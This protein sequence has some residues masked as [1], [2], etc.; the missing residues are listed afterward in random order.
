MSRR[1]VATDFGGPENLLLVDVDVPE[2]GPGQV[3]VAVRAAGV[4]PVDVKSYS[5]A[6]GTDP[7]QL[8]K[9]LGSEASGT[10]T[11]VGNDVDVRVGDEVA[12]FRAPGAYATDLLVEADAVVAKPAEVDWAD[13]AGLLLTGSTAMHALT[14]TDVA[15]GE[16]VLVHGGS[17]GVGLMAVQ[18]AAGRGARVIATASER[19][20]ALLRELGAEPVVYGAGLLE[21]VRGLAP[22]GV[23]AALDLIGTDEALE[24][25]LA[26]VEDRSRIATIVNFEGGGDAGIKVLGGGPGADPGDE[27]RQAARPD[28]LAMVARGELRVL[29]EATYPLAEAGEAHQRIAGGHVTGKLVLLP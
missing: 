15:E 12:V 4:N 3:R 19:N 2:P 5:G 21:R 18:L 27:L 28:L 1:V 17:G 26:L 29:V 13:A 9:P 25:S 16:T 8:P 24:V 6:F 23:H 10:V 20:H 11:A 22:D 7:A 14:A